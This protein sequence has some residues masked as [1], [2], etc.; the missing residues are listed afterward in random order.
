M[1]P[2]NFRRSVAEIYSFLRSLSLSPHHHH[3]HD[4]QRLT[5]RRLRQVIQEAWDAL[6][7]EWLWQ[8]AHGMP[9]R[10]RQVI[11]AGVGRIPY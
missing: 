2:T 6:D 9:R 7:L 5:P 10:L 1:H 11:W 3:H 4:I 8:L